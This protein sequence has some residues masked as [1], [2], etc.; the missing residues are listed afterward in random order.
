MK[1]SICLLLLIISC[2]TS[3]FAQDTLQVMPYAFNSS[4]LDFDIPV[5][6]SYYPDSSE[7]AFELLRPSPE[8][9]F[10]FIGKAAQTG[11]RVVLSD[12]ETSFTHFLSDLIFVPGGNYY[13]SFFG[14]P[15]NQEVRTRFVFA[16][17]ENL[18]DS[19]SENEIRSYVPV[20]KQP[21]PNMTR[22]LRKLKYPEKAR[23]AG[24]EGQVIVRVL[25]SMEGNY[26]SHF[27]L[28]SAHPEL[29]K[30]AEKAI[31]YLSFTPAYKLGKPTKVWVNVPVRF[32]I[33]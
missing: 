17:A 10:L 22:F 13:A 8:V 15:L 14:A 30:A 12:G 4:G 9:P 2:V 5:T 16:L 26:I 33:K 18:A 20:E 25:V 6:V 7:Q 27:V 11:A 32:K 29:D 1:A 31:P 21:V 3:V 19:L 24:I 28:Q 23:K